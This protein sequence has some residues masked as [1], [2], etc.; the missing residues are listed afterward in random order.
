[1]PVFIIDKLK[2]KNNGTFKLIETLDIDHKGYELGDFLDSLESKLNSVIENIGS[3]AKVVEMELVDDWICWKYTTE[4][5][6]AWRQLF[7]LSSYSSSGTTTASEIYVGDTEPTDENIKMWIDTSSSSSEDDTES[8]DYIEI[9][10]KLSELENNMGFITV[11][12]LIAN[13]SMKKS[14]DGTQ[15]ILAY[16]ENIISTI[17]I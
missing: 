12:D 11:D 2:P 6:T 16:G 4:D 14:D 1:M 9:P 7:D 8:D 5:E 13:L 10:T 15:V 3:E 17:D